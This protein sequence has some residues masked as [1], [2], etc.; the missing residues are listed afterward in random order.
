MSFQVEDARAM[1]FPYE[2]MLVITLEVANFT[3]QRLLMDNGNLANIIFWLALEAMGISR[4]QLEKSS[5]TLVG[6]DGKEI[7]LSGSIKLPITIGGVT[8]ITSFFA[9]DSP[10]A[11]N[12]ILGR[13]WI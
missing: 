8:Q 10:S 4:I 2:D 5:S 7:G 3:L 1:H 9:I 13:P 6:F 11:Y 12:A